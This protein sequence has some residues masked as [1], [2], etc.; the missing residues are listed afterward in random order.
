MTS[1]ASATPPTAA[2]PA[3]PDL[4][5]RDLTLDL[6]RVTCVVLV[7]IIHL[8]MVGVGE[9]P[10]GLVF[11]RPLEELWW[12]APATWV[13]QIM[14]LFFVVGGFAGITGLRSNR[15]R[16]GTD[17]DFVRTRALRLAQP[18]LP[19]FA[20]LAIALGIATA[21]GA[22]AAVIEAAATGVGSPLWFLA[23]Y[24]LVQSLVP[25]MV[26]WHERAPIQPLIVLPVAAVAVDALRYSTGIETIGLLNLAFVWLLV[27][28]FGFWYSD[29]WFDRRHPLTLVAI[30]AVCFAVLWP[31]TVLGPY[32]VSMLGN[33]NPP[34]VPLILLGL[35]QACLLRLLK[36]ALTALTNLRAV[37]GVMF[38]LGSRLMTIYLWHLPVILA[39]A[40]LGIA[41]P[42][43]APTPGTAAWWWSRIIVF[44][45]VMGLVLALSLLVGRIEEPW[46]SRPSPRTAIVV[47]GAVLAFIP[48]F[49]VME[50]FL[51]LPI[52]IVGTVL[53]AA[54]VALLVGRRPKA[55][56]AR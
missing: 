9:G 4:S 8:L 23:A 3:S 43:I 11:S 30:A 44:I 6:A 18:A 7:V 13:G 39:I 31:L 21:A 47:V 52:A 10:D 14:P 54:A 19:L 12:F 5:R 1:A 53:L 25:I 35:A 42:A 50:F 32:S 41:V 36:P 48:P 2:T 55:G 49:L 27:Q 24:L 51:D 33:L 28:Q 26:H 34:T 45:V 20:V 16:G 15:R 22:P 56:V 40:G 29:G 38:L 17:T 46:D 37:R